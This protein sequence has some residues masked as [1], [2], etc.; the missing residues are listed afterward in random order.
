MAD[1]FGSIVEQAYQSELGRPSDAEGAAYW[2]GLLESGAITP[3]D[4]SSLF[5]GTAEGTAFDQRGSTANLGGIAGLSTDVGGADNLGFVQQTYLDQVGRPGESA[6][7]EY[8]TN[9]L[10]SGA[11]TRDQLATAFSATEE[12]TAFDARGTEPTGTTGGGV[13]T[14]VQTT[15]D[16]GLR[17]FLEEKYRSEFGR[18]FDLP[19]LQYWEDQIQ[20]GNATKEQVADIF[21]KSAEGRKYDIANVATGKTDLG[22]VPPDLL[23]QY[24]DLQEAYKSTTYRPGDVEGLKYWLAN[25]TDYAKVLGASDEAFV[26]KTYRDVLKFAPDAKGLQY[27]MNQLSSGL[28][29]REDLAKALAAAQKQTVRE[30]DIAKNAVV[31]NPFT[32]TVYSNLA[33]SDRGSDFG[34]FPLLKRSTRVTDTGQVVPTVALNLQQRPRVS[35]GIRGFSPPPATAYQY[36]PASYSLF[37]GERLFGGTGASGATNFSIFGSQAAYQPTQTTGGTSSAASGAQAGEE[38]VAAANGGMIM[39]DPVMRRAMFRQGGPVSSTGTGITSN[40]ASPEENAKALQDMFQAPGF[41]KGG[42]VQY[43]QEGG[44][45]VDEE[46][47]PQGEVQMSALERLRAQTRNPEPR[48]KSVMDIYRE[49]RT[50]P[51]DREQ[52]YTG[53][54]MRGENVNEPSVDVSKPIPRP[55][56]AGIILGAYERAGGLSKIGEAIARNLPGSRGSVDVAGERAAAGSA[57]LARQAA[58]DQIAERE[59]YRQ[60]AEDEAR[61]R[62]NAASEQPTAEGNRLLTRLEDIRSQREAAAEKKREDRLNS[63]LQEREANKERRRENQL[64]ALMQAGLAAAAGR[65]PNALANIAA[66]GIS[67]VQ[68]LAELN[69]DVRAEDRALRREIIETELTQER[70]REAAAERQAAREERGLSREQTALKNLSDL[71][72]RYAIA[73][74][75]EQRDLRDVLKATSASSEEDKKAARSRLE[76]IDRELERRRLEEDRLSRALLPPG[77]RQSS[78]GF[79]VREVSSFPT[80]KK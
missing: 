45:A 41:R 61:Y 25:P 30:Q 44:E 56:I 1:D 66:G 33:M 76:A 40:V 39:S 32:S 64:L 13:S 28:V 55:G 19:G 27:W 6:G 18:P 17:S 5:S 77:M 51:I 9:L 3:G 65:S 20:K 74:G 24:Q 22:Y 78:G 46:V 14:T 4:L 53:R 52:E 73:A 23:K 34:G 50:L 47:A 71:N 7:V 80:Q 43:F 26:Q 12:G 57:Q 8:W 29:K 62:G 21:S 49:G 42:E 31:F 36:N 54:S 10:N 67:G 60:A 72:A 69:K 35:L 59:M 70:L 58:A 38:V 11:I 48:F 68:T 79:P 16:P 37:G 2:A 75:A 15:M 63:L